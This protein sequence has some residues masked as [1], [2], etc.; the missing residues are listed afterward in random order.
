ME[1]YLLPFLHTSKTWISKECLSIWSAVWNSRRLEETSQAIMALSASVRPLHKQLGGEITLPSLS[2][3]AALMQMLSLVTSPS[4]SPV[5]RRQACMSQAKL[6]KPVAYWN[7]QYPSAASIAGEHRNMSFVTRSGSCT[8]PPT[9]S[10]LEVS[11]SYEHS[12]FYRLGLYSCAP[13]LELEA[14]YS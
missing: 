9:K 7:G 4:V 5:R 13:I 11:D 12:V 8:L 3:V 10:S 1:R 6:L 2:N 14:Q